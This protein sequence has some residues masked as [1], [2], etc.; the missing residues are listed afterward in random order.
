MMIFDDFFEEIGTNFVE[1]R[2]ILKNAAGVSIFLS[3]LEPPFFST[4]QQGKYDG[5]HHEK[6][7]KG[8]A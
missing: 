6:E 4:K 7:R 8:I 1:M 5:N 3:G 2:K